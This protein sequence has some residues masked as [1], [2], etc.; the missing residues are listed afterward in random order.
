[1]WT[2]SSTPSTQSAPPLWA[3]SRTP[4]AAPDRPGRAVTGTVWMHP[5]HGRWLAQLTVGGAQ[6]LWCTSWGR[7]AATWIA[8]RLGLPGGL[9]VLDVTVG[10]V[11][12]GH[13]VTLFDLY[14]AVGD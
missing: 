5:E 2:A 4:I 1:M 10:D 11:H 9:P 8:P 12:W 6:L 14:E 3:T 7:L 13:Q